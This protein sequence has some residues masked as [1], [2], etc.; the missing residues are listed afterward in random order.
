MKLIEDSD[1]R[2]IHKDAYWKDNYVFRVANDGIAYC[3][4]KDLVEKVFYPIPTYIQDDI[5]LDDVSIILAEDYTAPV[6]CGYC[7]EPV[8]FS[9]QEYEQVFLL[10]PNCNQEL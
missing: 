3:R 5:V 7:F 1:A 2:V 9:G 6:R 8:Q 10:C 4:R